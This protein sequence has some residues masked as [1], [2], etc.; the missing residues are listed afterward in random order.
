MHNVRYLFIIVFRM[1]RSAAPSQI[2]GGE[3]LE[4]RPRFHPP[5]V[6]ASG[7]SSEQVTNSLCKETVQVSVLDDES[8]TVS[9]S[10][11]CKWSRM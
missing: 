4:K 6:G 5:F 9:F 2:V 7:N 10:Y 8:C 11:T 1:R 3:P